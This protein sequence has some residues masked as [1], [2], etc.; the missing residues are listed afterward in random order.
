MVLNQLH[1]LPATYLAATRNIERAAAQTERAH[2]NEQQNSTRGSR[3]R[4]LSID[5]DPDLVWV[6]WLER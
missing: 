1:L 4:R 2:P 6:W 5:A 3:G